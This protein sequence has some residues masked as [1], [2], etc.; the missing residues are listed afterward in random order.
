MASAVLNRSEK[1]GI[2]VLV[3]GAGVGGLMTALECWR[4][5]FDVRIIERTKGVVT[6]GDSFTIG[7][8]AVQAFKNW[9]FMEDEN[10][11][12]AYNPLVAYCK[13]NG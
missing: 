12:I 13:E 8:T 2:S 5:G 7:Y 11:K 1:N 4:R 10:E 9:P 3:S 6:T